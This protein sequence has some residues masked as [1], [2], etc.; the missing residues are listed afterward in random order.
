MELNIDTGVEEFSV[1]GRPFSAEKY[2]PNH[3]STSSTVM[4]T[5]M[6]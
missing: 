1:N 3:V 6:F 2:R 4:P 5:I